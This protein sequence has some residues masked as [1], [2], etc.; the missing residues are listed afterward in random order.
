LKNQISNVID[1]MQN[2]YVNY[3]LMIDIYNLI[4]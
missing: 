3:S 4:R 2:V 1:I